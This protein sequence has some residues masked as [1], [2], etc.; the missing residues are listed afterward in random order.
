MGDTKLLAFDIAARHHSSLSRLPVSV[1]ELCHVVGRAFLDAVPTSLY[2]NALAP[3]P[4]ELKSD[5]NHGK[6]ILQ[7]MATM[8][9][10]G[11]RKSPCV[12]LLPT[13]TH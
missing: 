10:A 13:I 2:Q 7:R 6:S 9:K 4:K 11:F 8:A 1:A 12:D 5:S 3:P